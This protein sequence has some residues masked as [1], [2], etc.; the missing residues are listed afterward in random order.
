MKWEGY[1]DSHNTWEPA[2]NL[3]SCRDMIEL[4]EKGLKDEGRV[5]PPT[6][7]DPPPSTSGENKKSTPAKSQPSAEVENN[8]QNKT[9][10]NNWNC[11]VIKVQKEK[12]DETVRGFRRGLEPEEILSSA[13]IRGGMCYLMKWYLDLLFC[14]SYGCQSVVCFYRKGSDNADLVS[15]REASEI[16]PMLVIKYLEQKIRWNAWKG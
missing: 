2:E 15:S 12:E 4:F 6:I 1:D 13:N 9:K 8:W 5:S 16:C 3:D 11:F 7:E 14:C 10:N